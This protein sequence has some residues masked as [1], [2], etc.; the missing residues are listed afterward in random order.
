M[1]AAHIAAKVI[2]E[3][4]GSNPITTLGKAMV[5]LIPG[6]ETFAITPNNAQRKPIGKIRSAP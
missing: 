6:K 4:T 3:A 2:P 1:S 5:A